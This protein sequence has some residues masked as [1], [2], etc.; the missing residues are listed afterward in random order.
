MTDTGSPA[1][2]R[3]A[4]VTLRMIAD[5][6]GVSVST[7]SRVLN[8]GDADAQ[9]WASAQTVARIRECAT[10]WAYR[11]NPHAA[12]LRTARSGLLRKGCSCG[13]GRSSPSHVTVIEPVMR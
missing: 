7:V 2:G 3:L 8:A 10:S 4:P 9:R 11:P 12:S 5:E 13:S 6:V 1:A